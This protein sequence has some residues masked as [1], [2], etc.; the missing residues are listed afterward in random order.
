MVFNRCLLCTLI[1]FITPVAFAQEVGYFLDT[2]FNPPRFFQRISWSEEEFAMYYEVLIQKDDGEYRDYRH[3]ST[4]ETFLNISLP[5]GKYRFSVMPYD[6]LGQTGQVSEWRA[7]E[8]LTA[9]QPALVKN[10]PPAFY[11]DFYSQ[12][13]LDITGNNLF[14]ETEVYLRNADNSLFAIDRNV[15]GTNR[16]TLFFDDE[17]LIPGTYEIY[18]RNPGGLET[19][20]GGFFVGYRRHVDF[21]I[22]L[23]WVPV[24]PIYGELF[25]TFD[26]ELY[27]AGAELN[28]G[29]ITTARSFFNYG[30]EL[31]AAANALNSIFALKSDLKSFVD[32]FLNAGTGESW[33]ELN[34]NLLMRKYFLKKLMAVT[35]RGGGGVSLFSQ[36]GENTDDYT[37]Q[38]SLGLSYM[39]QLLDVFHIETGIDFFQYHTSA[40]SGIIKPRL[41]MVWK[42]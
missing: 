1:I 26:S 11:M 34:L 29:V 35:L 7:F 14:D 23:S 18:I 24:V 27:L 33:A 40:P 3:E 36:N 32:S 30:L 31:S 2:S 38:W 15:W 25:D 39:L 16:I 41:G 9:F 37:F 28:F 6:L 4:E 5:P 8:I 42:F 19:I 12:R 13:K 17:N 22:K 10:Y 21:F 20:K